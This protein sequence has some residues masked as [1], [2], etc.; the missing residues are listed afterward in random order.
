MAIRK[1]AAYHEAAH[2]V[3][4]HYSKYHSLVKEINLMNFGAGE[5]FVS[6]SKSKCLRNNKPGDATA[7]FD[8]DVAKELA[9]IL[10]AGYRGEVIAA[11]K[12]SLVIPDESCSEPDYELAVQEL[13]GAGLSR[14]Y[15]FHQQTGTELLM[16]HWDHVEILA[17]KLFE[18]SKM[19]AVDI[20][21]LLDELQL[22]GS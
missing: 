14:R 3:I 21:E 9:V 22:Q 8:P 1:E 16:L 15:N 2:A 5:I 18:S 4:A 11:Q 6:L 19:D 20:I 13:K 10:C 12:D 7:R 17:N